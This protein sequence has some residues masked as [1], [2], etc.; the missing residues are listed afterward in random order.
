MG[1]IPIP[2][3][4]LWL[5][6]RWTTAFGI[7][8]ESYSI[9]LYIRLWAKKCGNR[10]RC[11]GVRERLI[12]AWMRHAKG[13]RMLLIEDT[14]TRSGTGPNLQKMENKALKKTLSW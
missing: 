11:T 8:G 6:V 9:N 5:L 4:Y 1:D 13:Q 2:G 10:S 3:G 7:C 14:F 12:K